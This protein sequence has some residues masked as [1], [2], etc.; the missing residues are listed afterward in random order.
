MSTKESYAKFSASLLPAEHRPPPPRREG[1]F[2]DISDLEFNIGNFHVIKLSN[3]PEKLYGLVRERCP[4]DCRKSCEHRKIIKFLK[5]K[6]QVRKETDDR[7]VAFFKKLESVGQKLILDK[8]GCTPAGESKRYLQRNHADN[9]AV[10]DYWWY[11]KPLEERKPA[12]EGQPE[13][14]EQEAQGE[15]EMDSQP[16]SPSSP[17][18]SATNPALD[19]GN[20]EQHESETQTETNVKGGPRPES[21]RNKK[22]HHNGHHSGKSSSRTTTAKDS[23]TS[24]PEREH[25]ETIEKRSG[26]WAR[27]R[28]K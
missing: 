9:C 6:K 11:K 20:S 7:K 5:K 28:R 17:Q 23:R 18:D 25:R 27:V 12:A 3:E 24:K 22:S 10:L 19:A 13:E 2:L 1:D 14:A 21:S 16:P 26:G 15:S 4:Y 8:Y